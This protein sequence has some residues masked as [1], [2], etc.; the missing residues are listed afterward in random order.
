[1]L[2]SLVWSLTHIYPSAI[3][4]SP[5][6]SVNLS[7]VKLP[8]KTFVPSAGIAFTLNANVATITGSSLN[9]VLVW[10]ILVAEVP[11]CAYGLD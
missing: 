7:P 9:V 11:N 2:G 5:K 1:M 10:N 3:E 4:G 8:C 6:L